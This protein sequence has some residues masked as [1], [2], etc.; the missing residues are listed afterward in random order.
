M[1]DTKKK[2][3]RLDKNKYDTL[4]IVSQVIASLGI[5]ILFFQYNHQI[6]IENE[7]KTSEALQTRKVS[8]LNFISKFQEPHLAD[9]R[10]KIFEIWT[11]PSVAPLIDND[12]SDR[13]SYDDF[14][15]A[16]IRSELELGHSSVQRSLFLLVDYF[17]LVHEC[18]EANVCVEAMV[19]DQLGSYG[20]RLN[21]LYGPFVRRA[22]KKLNDMYFGYGLC[23]ISGEAECL[24][25]FSDLKNASK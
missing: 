3:D 17:E 2:V 21:F 15:D 11:T 4:G 16:K 6:K 24:H 13:S 9:A 14:I 12:N 23:K 8:T 19:L 1:I 22:G 25:Y 7:L 20:K 10:Y 5:L 18:V